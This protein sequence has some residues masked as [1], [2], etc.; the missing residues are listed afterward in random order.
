[1]LATDETKSPDV[2]EHRPFDCRY[3]PGSSATRIHGSSRQAAILAGVL[4]VVSASSLYAQQNPAAAAAGP[5]AI[6]SLRY[7]EDYS[8]LRDR[9]NRTGNWWEA[10]KFI[11]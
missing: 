3:H 7:T 6:T 8:Y 2:P 9:E 11:Q 5:P 4:L 1:M 10:Y